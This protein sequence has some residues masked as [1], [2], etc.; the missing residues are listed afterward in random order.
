MSAQLLLAVSQAENNIPYKFKLT[1]INV[2]SFEEALYHVYAYWT[3]STDD[4][5][6]DEFLT[7]VSS[8][9]GL[10]FLASKIK[11]I[12]KI[13]AFSERL[14]SF[15]SIIDYFDEIQ[16]VSLRS[17]LLEWEKTCEWERLKVRADYLLDNKDPYAAISFYKKALELQENVVLLNNIAIALMQ[18]CC[19]QE[20]E[21]YLEKAYGIDGNNIDIV[22]HLTE[23]AIYNHNFE[24]AL[25]MLCVAEQ[26]EPKNAD[27]QFLHGELNYEMGNVR[28]SID[29]FEKA[30]ELKKD[31]F[32]VY[33]L[34]DVYVKLRLYEKA[35]SSLDKVLFKERN[36]LMKQADIYVKF[37]NVPAAIKCI[38][39]ALVVDNNDA[40]LW[41]KLAMYHRIDYDHIHAAIAIDKALKIAP[42]D[43]KAKLENA[44]IKKA[45][46]KIKEYQLILSDILTSFK[47]KYRT[48]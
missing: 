19:F 6:S 5:V 11:E 24:K 7:W 15:L 42:N 12:S 2:Y 41:V 46:G 16:L 14:L 40:E 43:Q 8:T 27:I 29:Y 18:L 26:I 1:N 37:N 45:Q 3:Q 9:L 39:Q 13:E 22:L 31:A 21:Y 38:K 30:F 10:S 28:Y 25:R 34:A 44:R 20:A 4:F 23:A 48:H 36:F 47:H 17:R 32:Y 35:L 33:R